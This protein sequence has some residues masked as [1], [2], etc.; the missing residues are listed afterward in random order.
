MSNTCLETEAAQHRTKNRANSANA[1]YSDHRV[2]RRCF[3][4]KGRVVL[5]Y[6][7]LLPKASY[8]LMISLLSQVLWGVKWICTP[9]QD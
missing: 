8:L 7:E 9:N 6:D 4:C 3:R 1:L 2:L 5:L